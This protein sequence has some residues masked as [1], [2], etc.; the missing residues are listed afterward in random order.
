ML[1]KRDG[2]GGSLGRGPLDLT[3][4]FANKSWWL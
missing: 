2:E 3:L 4:Y 1:G